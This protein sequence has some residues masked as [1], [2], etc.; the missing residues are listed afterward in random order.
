MK[1]ADLDERDEWM[2]DTRQLA[3]S[4]LASEDESPTEKTEKILLSDLSASN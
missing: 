1:E 2:F 4:S 3:G